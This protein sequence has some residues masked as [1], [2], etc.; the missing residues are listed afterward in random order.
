MAVEQRTQHFLPARC[1]RRLLRGANDRRFLQVVSLRLGFRA[2]VFGTAGQVP[3]RRASIGSVGGCHAGMRGIASS[4]SGFGGPA[5]GFSLVPPNPSV[6]RTPNSFAR[7]PSSA[8]A[9]PHFA[10]A[11]CRAK[12][13]GSAYLQ[14]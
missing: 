9:S 8:G 6:K 11:V 5:L 1:R 4:F 10:L 13:S 12:L 7:Q 3:L 14:R 2:S